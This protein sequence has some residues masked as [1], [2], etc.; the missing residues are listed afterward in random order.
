MGTVIFMV[1]R[2][3]Q[4]LSV[5]TRRVVV[6]CAAFDAGMKTVAL[7]DLARRPS[8]Q[9]QGSKAAWATAIALVN[10]LGVIPTLYLA[11]GRRRE[12][13]GDR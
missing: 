5:R 8:S 12:P 10:S 2:K 4:D 11:R 1:R 13:V 7:I 9:I 3:W 6:I